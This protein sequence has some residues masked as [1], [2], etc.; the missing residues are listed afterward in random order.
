[1]QILRE[2]K[3]HFPTLRSQSDH[4]SPETC[5]TWWPGPQQAQR[6]ALLPSLLLQLTAHTDADP[7]R[8][9]DGE[10]AA[11]LQQAAQGPGTA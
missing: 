4:K 2:A 3:T 6:L 9:V 5:P 8:Q 1:M 11:D 7:A 10:P